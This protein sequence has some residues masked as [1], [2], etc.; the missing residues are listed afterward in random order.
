MLERTGLR[1]TCH[2]FQSFDR[3]LFLPLQQQFLSL[4]I[5]EKFHLCLRNFTT[6]FC[7]GEKLDI[8]DI[9]ECRISQMFY[10]SA[11][12]YTN[13]F[14]LTLLFSNPVIQCRCHQVQ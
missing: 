1:E 8:S 6:F 4:R 12:K 11:K 9:M 14:Q 7:L 13:I 3:S 10:V 5:S 2:S